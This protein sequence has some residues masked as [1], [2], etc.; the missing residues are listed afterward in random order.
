MMLRDFHAVLADVGSSAVE[1]SR[2]S[3]GLHLRQ[4][5]IVEVPESKS[6]S[7]HGGSETEEVEEISV[8]QCTGGNAGAPGENQSQN[9]PSFAPAVQTFVRHC[10]E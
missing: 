9:A 1:G 5:P 6:P 4:P 3:S 8:D 2:L 10:R 7:V